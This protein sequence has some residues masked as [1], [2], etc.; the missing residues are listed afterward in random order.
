MTRVPLVGNWTSFSSFFLSLNRIQTFCLILSGFFL[1]L[2]IYSLKLNFRQPPLSL[3]DTITQLLHVEWL[4]ISRCFPFIICQATQK[5]K[6]KKKPHPLKN[7]E[8]VRLGNPAV[9]ILR[10]ISIKGSEWS[11]DNLCC[12]Q[13]R[14]IR[15][16][17]RDPA[18]HCRVQE[19]ASFTTKGNL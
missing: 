5:K 4:S 15:Q 14:S 9:E 2:C 3:W 10:Q 12:Q 11:A 19:P 17:K 6:K 18:G 1:L 8:N 7:D 16:T 13:R